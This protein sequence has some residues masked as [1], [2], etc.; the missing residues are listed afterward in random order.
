M[1]HCVNCMDEFRYDDTGG[2]NPPCECGARCRSCCDAGCDDDE[3]DTRDDDE[4]D[5]YCSCPECISDRSLLG[6]REA[7]S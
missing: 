4:H 6:E 2:Y 3:V 7:S 5:V 1:S